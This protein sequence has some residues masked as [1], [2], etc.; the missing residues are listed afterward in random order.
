MSHPGHFIPC[1]KSLWYPL[2]RRLHVLKHWSGCRGMDTPMRYEPNSVNIQP[3]CIPLS[4]LL[5]GQFQP[6]HIF[7]LMNNVFGTHSQKAKVTCLQTLC[8]SL[9]VK[10][11]LKENGSLNLM[12]YRPY[13]VINVLLFPQL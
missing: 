4:I 6:L 10:S 12:S 9:G 11:E 13:Q 1:S 7:V 3:I 2:H 5:V 8:R